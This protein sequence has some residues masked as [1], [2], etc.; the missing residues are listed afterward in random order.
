MILSYKSSMGRGE[1]SLHGV[2]G[3]AAK[4]NPQGLKPH[5]VGDDSFVRDNKPNRHSPM[6]RTGASGNLGQ[7]LRFP[8]HCDTR[9]PLARG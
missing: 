9:S 7:R 3:T 4:W 1:A 8:L 2:A 5:A 6:R